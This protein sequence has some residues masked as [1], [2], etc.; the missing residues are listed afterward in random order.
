MRF[1]RVVIIILPVII[2]ISILAVRYIQLENKEKLEPHTKATKTNTNPALYTQEEQIEALSRFASLYNASVEE[3]KKDFEDG[4]YVIPGLL[5]TKTLSLETNKVAM[6]TTMTPQGVAVSDEYLFISAYSHYQAYHSVIYVLDRK[7]HKYLKTVVLQ[8]HP[9]VGGIAYDPQFRNLM[10]CGRH[11]DEAEIFTIS[12]DTIESYNFDKAKEPIQYKYRFSLPHIKRASFLSYHN[13]YIYVGLY[14]DK[15][16]SILQ[17]YQ[18]DIDGSIKED[19]KQTVM[20]AEKKPTDTLKETYKIAGEIQGITFYKDKLLL[21][22]SNG[23]FQ[24]SEILVFDNAGQSKVF[25]QDDAIQKIPMPERLEQIYVDEKTNNMFI[26][27]ES[28]SY[29]YRFLA[30]TK[31]DRVLQLDLNSL[32]K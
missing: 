21:S 23:P 31:V 9:H 27:F 25:L 2:F 24:N 29:A 6:S 30:F 12:L 8:G 10:V 16:D 19:I 17:S 1:K 13:G 7:S 26:I 3:H 32:L 4:M 11:N 5:A 14:S 18:I 20:L 22:R 28:A 15:A